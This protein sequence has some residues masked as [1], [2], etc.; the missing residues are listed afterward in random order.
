MCSSL[1]ILLFSFWV[2]VAVVLKVTAPQGLRIPP[3]VLP[4]IIIVSFFR[5][6]LRNSWNFTYLKGAR[7]AQVCISETARM[8]GW[9]LFLATRNYFTL[10]SGLFPL[11]SKTNN[12]T[13]F[14][15]DLEHKNWH[16]KRVL[17]SLKGFR[18]QNNS[19]STFL[20]CSS[21]SCV[22][23]ESLFRPE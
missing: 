22:T 16:V 13:K 3:W 15:F 4:L 10:Y 6:P 14:E 8:V 21:C 12:S 18:G 11:N 17:E 2:P 5:I 7:F 1:N 19:C 23:S 20:V 9:S